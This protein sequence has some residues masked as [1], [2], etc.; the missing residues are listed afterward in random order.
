[1]LV[2]IS[3]Y[4]RSGSS[5][6]QQTINTFFEKPWTSV[7]TTDRARPLEKITGCPDYFK[8]WRYDQT[9]FSKKTTVLHQTLER[10]NSRTFKL[11]NLEKWI[12]LY[13]L[14]I[15][16]Y[17]KNCRYLL[18]GCFNVLTKKN[19]NI[20]AN[21]ETCFFVK[22][23][24]LPYSQYFDN[25]YVIQIVRNPYNVFVSYKQFIKKFHNQDKDINE[26]I[27]GNVPFG[28][29]SHWHNAWNQ[30]ALKLKPRFLQIKFENILQSD[31]SKVCEEIASMISLPYK[32]N[33]HEPSW[34]DLQKINPNYYRSGNIN[35]EAVCNSYN[36]E[37]VNLI[38][39]LH[40][41]TLKQ[42]G[43]QFEKAV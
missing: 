35:G 16:P 3:S 28:S 12:A 42:L 43:Y 36:Q 30:V 6:V 24:Y 1:M 41:A 21:E 27:K 25:E 37:Q 5:L 7:H 19:R 20:L 4:P 2:Y 40:G 33:S 13:D 32:E 26:V 22:T 15:P 14:N 39:T 18:P 9:V 10:L 34:E 8:N 38:E 11:Y 29:W 17:T 23:H 31:R